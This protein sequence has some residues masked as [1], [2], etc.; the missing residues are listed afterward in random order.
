M[1]NTKDLQN[2]ISKQI[3]TFCCP[4]VVLWNYLSHSQPW[5][6]C[7]KPLPVPHGGAPEHT[8]HGRAGMDLGLTSSAVEQAKLWKPWPWPGLLQQEPW[9]QWKG[10]AGAQGQP[11]LHCG[12][13]GVHGRKN[14]K[15]CTENLPWLLPLLHI[16]HPASQSPGDCTHP[17]E[18]MAYFYTTFP[19]E[20]SLC[21]QDPEAEKD[22]FVVTGAQYLTPHKPNKTSDKKWDRPTYGN[23]CNSRDLEA[24]NKMPSTITR[25]SH[26]PRGAVAL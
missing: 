14:P 2:S 3:W 11:E 16:R 9:K 13:G 25:G 7:G 12:D 17:H 10:P 19:A 6:A 18:Q 5:N 21:E 15:N 20:V 22:W 8:Q 1:W 23:I 26:T 4:L 24:Q